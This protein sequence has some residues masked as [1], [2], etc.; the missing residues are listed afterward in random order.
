[1]R[2]IVTWIIRWLRQ[3]ASERDR[4]A[5]TPTEAKP[6]QRSIAL[7]GPY[8]LVFC[9]PPCGGKS[10]VLDAFKR[11]HPEVCCYEMDSIRLNKLPGPINDD[12]A[13]GAAYRI[14]HFYS[15]RDLKAKRPVT[16][17]ATY[18]PARQ[19]AELAALVVRQNVPLYVVQCVCFPNTATK[20][21]EER[22]LRIR[23]R[24]EPEHAGS[25]LTITRVRQLAEQ[26]VRFD[27]A[28][29][30]NTDGGD[31]PTDEDHEDNLRRVYAFLNRRVPTDPIR[32]ARHDYFGQ[33]QNTPSPS[34]KLSEASVR[35]AR[36]HDRG[37]WLGACSIV[38]GVLLGLL[39]LAKSVWL[40]YSH[41]APWYSNLRQTQGW[42]HAVVA[43]L[44]GSLNRLLADGIGDPF[45]DWVHFGTFSLAAAG[46]ASIAVAYLHE[47]RRR[48]HYAK[49]VATAGKNPFY[50]LFPAAGA[51][52]SDREVFHAYRER[53]RLDQIPKNI[54][55]ENVPVFFHILPKHNNSFRTIANTGT[56]VPSVLPADAVKLGFDWRGF[57]MWRNESRNSE[58]P[59]A[60]RH[61]YGL[62]CVSLNPPSGDPS[63]CTLGVVRSSYSDYVCTEH[64]V[65]L[66]SPGVLPDMRY[67]MEG[68]SWDIGNLDLCE[69]EKSATRYSM[70]ISTT[71]LIL[72]KDDYFVL[73]RRSQRVATGTGNLGGASSGAADY[74]ADS[75]CWVPGIVFR[76][77][78]KAFTIVPWPRISHP[79]LWMVPWPRPWKW[80]LRETA[81]RETKE[82][83]GLKIGDFERNRSDKYVPPFDCPFIGAA[84]NLLYGRDLNFYCC[85]RTKLSS[86][87]LNDRVRRRSTRD[88]W[89]VDH[90]VFLDRNKVNTVAIQSGEIDTLLPNRSRHLLGALY[91]WAIYTNRTH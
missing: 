54:P 90:L 66:V 35:S 28:F 60:Y 57:A 85:F 25:D 64:S 37:F 1:M 65:N 59:F 81:L 9:G 16:L 50:S 38:I 12:G 46:V 67:L 14:M 40:L 32:W 86:S 36:M 87:Q 22:L 34:T 15:A 77:Y 6:A 76:I 13:R 79:A 75:S 88:K 62:R 61:E 69:I 2:S 91:A 52:P 68:H 19:R 4:S 51:D 63:V 27:G 44:W 55:I 43:S 29:L 72:T 3:S 58:Y 49:T 30:L 18:M 39:P 10:F 80:D 89:E 45:V 5:V 11:A 47:V 74:F 23:R 84:Y 78:G 7:T 41:M 21:F 26:Y 8:V 53:L 31:I 48:W 20:R 24:S 83:I 17:N 70:R 33:P 56:S 71:N 73:Q 82:E 42:I